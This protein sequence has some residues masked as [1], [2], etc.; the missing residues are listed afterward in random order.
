MLE[1]PLAIRRA[2]A[3]V[4]F[5]QPSSDAPALLQG[6]GVPLPSPGQTT[7]K[8]TGKSNTTSRSSTKGPEPKP[9]QPSTASNT[10]STS[11]SPQAASSS[12]SNS[13]QPLLQSG[14][15]H[16]EIRTAPL[17]TE[18]TTRERMSHSHPV[19]QSQDAKKCRRGPLLATERSIGLDVTQPQLVG[20]ECP[21][22]PM[23][24]P[25]LKFRLDG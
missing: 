18:R 7:E 2:P 21:P 20:P 17:A 8:L 19:S 22:P 4:L 13:F 6:Q 15:R 14:L 16:S 23:S 24:V 11:T 1:D 9:P 3:P 5:A 10:N 12:N 25:S